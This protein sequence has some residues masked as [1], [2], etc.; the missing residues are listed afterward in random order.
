MIA[1]SDTNGM[2]A[3][4]Q[5]FI[6]SS[7]WYAAARLH[8]HTHTHTTTAHAAATAHARA[9]VPCR[10]RWLQALVMQWNSFFVQAVFFVLGLYN[11]Y[12]STMIRDMGASPLDSG[13]P[14]LALAL[15]CPTTEIGS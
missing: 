7:G 5:Q 9:P 12:F 1:V 15:A 13:T 8:T 14:P 11:C 4:V 10:P 2:D 3:S 6:R